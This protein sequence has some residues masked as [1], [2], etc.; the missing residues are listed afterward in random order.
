MKSIFLPLCCLCFFIPSS[1]Q[2]NLQLDLVSNA[3][4]AVTDITN[5]GD[6]RLFVVEQAGR[7]QIIQ[8]DGTVN[9]TP[10]LDIDAQVRSGGESGLL[11]L[12]FHPNYGENGYF[13]VN[14][15][16]NDGNTVVS[17]FEVSSGDP[18]LADVTSE[19][20]L[21][22]LIQPEGN[23]NGGDINFG[24]EGYFY[25]ATGD[26]GG[27]GDTRNYSQ[28]PGQP[29]GKI[30]RIDVD[31]G[32]GS[33]PDYNLGSNYTIP[34]SN[35]LI[36]GPGGDLDEIWALGLRNPWRFS[37]DR[38]TGDMW[39]GDVGQ[40]EWE[41]I[42]FEPAGSPGGLN[43]G[44]R[45]YEGNED[46]NTTGCGPAGTYTFPLFEYGHD[47]GCSVNGGFVYRGSCPALYGLYLYS[48]YCTGRI[49]AL[50]EVGGEWQNEELLQNAGAQFAT[51]G[52]DYL[53][54]LYLGSLNGSVFRITDTSCSG[55]CSDLIVD[56]QD[57]PDG[58]Y[59]A[60]L[61]LTGTGTV[62][63]GAD[64]TFKAEE[65]ILLQTG[66]KAQMG[67]AFLAMIE[68]CEPVTSAVAKPSIQVNDT[69]ASSA[70]EVRLFPNPLKAS[71]TIRY[72][73]PQAA[74]VDI[75]VWDLYGQVV[76]QP[77]KTLIQQAGV[78]DLLFEAKELPAGVYLVIIR[79]GDQQR[80]E[81][82]EIAR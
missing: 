8:A 28:N 7:I 82:M 12:A 74:E 60:G 10:F 20:I 23:H 15:I 81:R 54:G 61:Q 5:A 78:H 62:T 27:A 3:F 77:V 66:F 56:E 32:S 30:L 38:L 53:G 36:D 65:S 72:T 46:Y 49:W 76:A 25:I 57:I 70:L 1:A 48:D 59:Q 44:W 55:D 24:P 52:Q 63:T 40:A 2:I 37:F 47:V 41:E 14:Y 39:I 4:S 19:T 9:T 18:D 79:A 68:D 17:R 31:S 45:C 43:Y 13:F 69:P 80:V 11:G 64:V 67:S 50:E 16:N 6:D 29:F 75:Q 73:L 35:P 71:T 22:T 51:M 34:P 58:T 33:G 26:G 42:D 21:L